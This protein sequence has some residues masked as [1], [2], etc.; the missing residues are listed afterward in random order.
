MR[1]LGSVL[2]ALGFLLGSYVTVLNEWTVNWGLFL[3]ALGVGVAGVIVARVT[4]RRD[5]QA[6][7][8][9][10]ANIESL[11]SSLQRIVEEIRKMNAEKDDIPV[12][13]LAPRI[14][15]TFM[16]ELNTFVEARESIGHRYSLQDYA[17]VMSHFAAGERYL[18]RIWS[19]SGDGYIEEAHEYLN[20]AET[21][22]TEARERLMNLQSSR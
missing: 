11:E 9:V 16:D 15:N 22:F 12:N 7:D 14:D 3:P 8:T 1:Y 6:E 13:R 18:N 20:R 4:H 19:A 21:Q 2:I 10:A 17:D 5:L